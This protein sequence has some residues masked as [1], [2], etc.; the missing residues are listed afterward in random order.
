MLFLVAT[1]IGNLADI[2][3]RALEVLRTCDYILCED[4]RHS[5]KLLR[6]YEIQKPLRS[7]HKFN[8]KKRCDEITRDLKAGMKIALIT[9]AGTPLISDP[10]EILVQ[11]CIEEKLS[12]I[13]IPGPCAAIAALTLSGFSAAQFQLISFLPKK[14]GGLTRVRTARLSDPGTSICYESPYRLAT[15]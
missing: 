9:D 5:L 14:S 11:K 8:E 3:L 15:T 12:V 4:T 6:H 7:Y 1:P 10:G 2:T 13:P